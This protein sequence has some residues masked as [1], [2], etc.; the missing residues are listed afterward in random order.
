MKK[1]AQKN[2]QSAFLEQSFLKKHKIFVREELSC[3]IFFG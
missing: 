3:V 1:K 2:K